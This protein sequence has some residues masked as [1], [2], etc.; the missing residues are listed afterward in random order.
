MRQ[1]MRT[2]KPLPQ[3]QNYVGIW[4]Y[5]NYE[6]TI[7]SAIQNVMYDVSNWISFVSKQT[8]T[9]YII[10]CNNNLLI[11]NQQKYMS[12]RVCFKSV[13]VSL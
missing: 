8:K 4:Y 5:A 9:F 12:K 3:I 7:T 1:K 2:K 11:D 6:Q 10:S 13:S